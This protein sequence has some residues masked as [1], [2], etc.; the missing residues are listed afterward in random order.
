[1]A[2]MGGRGG[3]VNY[4]GVWGDIVAHI[5]IGDFMGGHKKGGVGKRHRNGKSGFVVFVSFLASFFV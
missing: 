5:K 4:F 3:M 2:I 1:M